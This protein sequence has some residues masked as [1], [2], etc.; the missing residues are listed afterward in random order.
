MVGGYGE[1]LE[2]T[3]RWEFLL[4]LGVRGTSYERGMR[5]V[6]SLMMGL[7]FLRVSSFLVRLLWSIMREKL[8][9]REL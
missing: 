9:L 3:L 1:K 5:L 7:L 8:G 6:G 4:E 2:E